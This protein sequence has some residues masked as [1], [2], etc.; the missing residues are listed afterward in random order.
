MQ[1]NKLITWKEKEKAIRD[2]FETNMLRAKKRFDLELF[3]KKYLSHY[4]FMI[5]DHNEHFS[6]YFNLQNKDLNNE[7]LLK[8]IQEI[9]GLFVYDEHGPHY[10]FK[11]GSDL[12]VT[13]SPLKVHCHNGIHND[14]HVQVEFPSCFK[15]KTH[16]VFKLPYSYYEGMTRVEKRRVNEI[17]ADSMRL[18]Q[19]ERR[20]MR[21]NTEYIYLF[22]RKNFYGGHVYVYCS[23]DGEFGKEYFE[24]II[25][26]GNN[27]EH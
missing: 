2:E 21:L 15:H 7:S 13:N 18:T 4:D 6:V 25:L 5:V 12:I 11:H 17:E 23:V 10:S 19:K 27:Y 24:S 8:S 14:K 16:I 20:D 26:Q 22:E 9:M 1:K 3:C